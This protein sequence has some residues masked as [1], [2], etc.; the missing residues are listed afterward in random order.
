ME[1]REHDIF[2]EMLDNPTA[3]FDTMVTVGLNPTNTSLQSRD[4]Y[5]RDQWVIDNFKNQYGQFDETAFNK[6]YDVANML[7]NNLAKSSYEESMKKQASFHRDNI[8]APV[9]QRRSGPDFKQIKIANP[10]EQ[11]YNLNTLGRIDQPTKSIDELAQSH[12][13]LSNPTTAGKNLENAIWDDSPNDKFWGNFFETLVLAQYDEDGTHID[14]TSGETVEHKKG[15]F[16]LN[17]EGQFYYEK[18][19]GRDVYG[20]RIL[21]KMNVLTTDGSFWNKY[22]FFDS[23]DIEQKSIGGTALKNLA[24]VGSMFIP[25][26]GPWI[27]GFSIA[28][29]LAGLGATFGKMA[30]GSDNS[31]LS[32]IEGWSKSMNRQN[33]KTQYAQENTWCWENFI[34]LIGDVMGQLKEQRFIFEKL[35][36]AIKGTNVMT[37]SGRAA[38]LEELIGKRNTLTNQQLEKLAKD[39]DLVSSLGRAQ[40]ELDAVQTLKAQADLDSF[41]KGYQKLGEVFS[42][43]YMTAIT[44]GDTY[45]EAKLAGASDLDATLLTLGYAAGEYALLSTGLGEW[46][47][48]ELRANRYK[49][50]AIAKALTQLDSETQNLRQQFG[51]T[52]KNFPKEQKK[53]YTKKLF[54]IGKNIATAEYA[55]G[56]K[57]LTASLAAG[58]GEGFEEVSEEVLADFSKGCYDVVNWLRGDS[59]RLNTFGYDF[60]KG[61]WDASGTLDRYGMSL[62]GGFI[63]GGLTNVAT[64]YNSINS[65]NNMTSQQAI[66]EMVYM[67]RNGGLQDFLKQVDKMQLGDQNLS[68]TDFQ[69]QKDGSIVFSPGTQT[70]NQDLYAKQAIKQQAKL[71]ESILQAN[72]AALSDKSFL[73]VQTLGDLR[74]NALHQS[75]TAGA[76]LNE[77]N[78][79]S[80]DLVKLTNR[81]NQQ[82]ASQADTNQDG[83][84][85]DKEKRE[86]SSTDN[87]KQIIKQ[88]EEQIKDT[89]QQLQDLVQGKRSYEFIADSLF[90]MTNNLSSKFTTTT[91]PL[92]AERKYGRKFSELTENDKAVAW[93]EYEQWKSGEGR[94]RIREMSAIYRQIA[95]QASSVIKDHQAEY[96]RN[97]QEL[98]NLDRIVSNLYNP[99]VGVS[100]ELWLES[101]Q[102]FQNS[103][104]AQLKHD[105][106]FTFGTEEDKKYITEIED[107]IRQIDPNLSKEEKDKIA[108]DL[109]TK[110][111]KKQ[112]EII[113]N[114]INIYID[115]IIKAGFINTETKAQISRVLNNLTDIARNEAVSAEQNQDPFDPSSEDQIIYWSNKT[116]ELQNIQKQVDGLSNT[117]FEKNL[118]EFSISIGNDPINITQLLEKLNASLEDSSDNITKFNM[119]E[120]LYRNLDNAIQTIQLYQA[121]ILGARTDA[122]GIDNYYGYNA[123]LNEVSQQMDDKR[124]ELAEI[125]SNTADIFIEDINTNLN[126]L[127]FLKKLYQINQ[128]QKMSKQDRVSTKKDI[129]I[130]RRLKN[131]VTVPDDDNLKTWNGFLEL[132][133]A[134]N[135]MS[136]HE[137]LSQSNSDNVPENQKADFEKE[138]I[139]IEDAIYDFFQANSDKLNDTNK[140]SEF[141]N[142]NKLQIYTNADG[143]LNEGLESLDDNSILW[144]LAGRAA[145]K[146]SDFYNQYRQI[147]DPKAKNPLAPIPTQELAVYE[148]YASIVNGTVFTQFYKAIRQSI[149]NDW[150]K[151]SIDQRREI[152]KS[153]NKP[154]EFAQDSFSDY[155]LDI[156]SVPRYSN[157]VLTEGIPGSGKTSAVFKQTIELL[158]KFNPDLL[159]NVA[160]VH[161]ADIDSAKKISQ[162]T[163]LP[164][165]KVY[166]REEWMREVNPEWKEYSIDPTTDKY[167]VPESDFQFT[168]E[169]EI[170]SALGIKETSD[171]P[172]LVIIDEI[173]KF[174]VYDLDQIDK[175]A[176]KYGITV[177]AAGD[178]DQSGVIGQ[179][180]VTINGQKYGWEMELERTNFIRSPKL[181]VSMRTDN[182]LKTEDLQKFQAYMQDPDNGEVE[183][184]YF[185]DETGLYG[186]KVH[187]YGMDEGVLGVLQSVLQD[188]DSLISTLKDGEKIGYIYSDKNSDIYKELSSDKYS[189]YIDFKKG[190]TA[191]GL[192]GRYYIIEASPSANLQSD[193]PLVRYSARRRYLRDIYTGISR[194]QQGSI[195]IAPLNDIKFKSTKVSQKVNESVGSNVI[196]QYANRRKTLLDDVA[197]SGSNIKYIPRQTENREVVK[198][199]KPISSTGLEDG[200]D[201]TP[202]PT[203]QPS[204]DTIIKQIQ[205]AEDVAE[206]DLIEYTYKDSPI[207]NN[208]EVQKA[209]SEK[210]RE[211]DPE[212]ST[213]PIISITDIPENLREDILKAQEAARANPRTDIGLDQDDSKSDLKYGQI[214]KLSS[215]FGVI[216][217]VK[218]RNNGN[219]SY[220][221]LRPTSPRTDNIWGY[222]SWPYF[223]RN[224]TA[225]VREFPNKSTSNEEHQPQAEPLSYEEDQT[226]ITNTDII[227]QKEY[228]QNIDQS[229]QEEYLPQSNAIQNDS[230]SVGIEMLLHTFN[231]FETGVLIG[232]DGKPLPVGDQSWADARIDSVNGLVKIDQLLGKSTRTVRQ[233]IEQIGRLRS[234][235]FNIKDKSE[236]AQ[237]L[238]T[239]LGLPDIYITFALKSSPRPGDGNK[240]QGREFVESKPTP[241]SKGISE[242][243]V[244]NG[245]SDTRSHEWHP[246]SVVAIIGTKSNGNILELPLMAMSSPFTL[247]Q[248]K[249]ENGG[250]VYQ[251][252]YDQFQQ[253]QL[254]GMSIHDISNSLIKQFDG[255]PI[256]KDLINLFKLFNFTERGIS[257]IKDNEWTPAKSLTLVGPQFV[258]NRGYYQGVPGLEYD[259][260]SIPESEWQSV[261]EFATNPQCYVTKKVLVSLS[262]LADTG[263]GTSIKI[264]NAGHPF[265]LVSYDRE[266]NSDKKVIDYYIRQ[267]SDSSALPKVKLMYILPPKASIEEYVENLRKI[268]NREQGVKNIGQLFTSYK[269]IKALLTSD[270][271]KTELERKSPGVLSKVTKA[272]E[273]IDSLP[274]V[275]SKKNKLYEPQNWSDVGISAKPVKLAGLFDGV[276][277][278]FLYNKN[279]LNSLIGGQNQFTLDSQSLEL[280]KAVLQQQGIDGIYYNVKIPKDGGEQI[281]PFNVPIQG[282]NYTLDGKPFTIHGKLDSYVFKGNMNWLVDSFLNS[283]RPSKDGRYQFTIDGYSYLKGESDIGTQQITPQQREIN[284]LIT[285]IKQKIGSDFSDTYQNY[286]TQEAN[287][288]IV[289]TINSTDNSRIA[290]TIGNRLIISNQNQALVGNVWLTDNSNNPVTDIQQFANNNGIYNF[291]VFVR[292]SSYVAEFNNNTEE[293][294]LTP[295]I[296]EQQI[297]STLSVTAES[298]NNYMENARIALEDMLIWDP[299]YDQIF[300]STTYEEFIEAINNSDIIGD[301]RI[302]DL[303]NALDNQGITPEQKSIIEELINFEKARDNAEKQDSCPISIKIKF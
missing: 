139:Q 62:V 53:E 161:G 8:W 83:T 196:S 266:L 285:Y 92:Y 110:L 272:V 50:Q 46:I 67:S 72:G 136:L 122:A 184:Q 74:F 134:I 156:I 127:Q 227:P 120:Q 188:V 82:L 180:P 210:R 231:T 38:K 107:Q 157:I 173:S 244:F 232:S 261:S 219:H 149:V 170:R 40:T 209:L 264:A 259:N 35:P 217:G 31:T 283:L 275:I 155:A 247:L 214:V 63:G 126:K 64:N 295:E 117:P 271:F 257:Y 145:V 213:L 103:S 236:L 137:S 45:E 212:D 115:P 60:D 288:Q 191:Q 205:E 235:I 277:M 216:V 165:S 240:A 163:N 125:D 1:K 48:P 106:V 5:K 265:V 182:S 248:I 181:G 234:L 39:P 144:W 179:H 221:V 250:Y 239:N 270:S 207:L 194:A 276:L 119:D 301:E 230:E 204:I 65:I 25:Y 14:P 201:S 9:E 100:E 111:V 154:E 51:A 220:E 79:L 224:I 291:K 281:G 116:V 101:T 105:L 71:I 132:Q 135:G 290:F 61:E 15:D 102:Q 113:L 237:K 171:P 229:N 294:T 129:L 147:I 47:L 195:L 12:K 218:L 225:V 193:Q 267:Q 167:L 176:R 37:E 59:T 246:K 13:V 254:E 199:T 202:P 42:K 169:N 150:K 286:S 241:F 158:R 197:P 93:K 222:E 168:E 7:Y 298:F 81:L 114:N 138:K 178:F 86:S 75:T 289:G 203:S 133:N 87:N 68:A 20:K 2:M 280:V 166:G 89:K 253:L 54:N 249:D 66:Q 18:L 172:S 104:I 28:T 97:Y 128:G 23:D 215:E 303:N 41:I 141:L 206:V 118:N 19:D 268:L 175:F 190:G 243:T 200:A 108:K 228:Q 140:L 130:Y 255:N 208:P 282:N 177:L 258:T 124:P 30:A 77:F 186:D 162:D 123:T 148:N 70:N 185:S 131:I 95:E 299:D 56:A 34:G 159:K 274:D 211:V 263:N 3:S 174:S 160:I 293:L 153:L 256:Y 192:E 24:L 287:K 96:L 88:L 164:E 11:V 94:D 183:F 242:Q 36:Y 273:E 262:G 55:N 143:L 269:L 73:D 278:T 21:N 279:T 49:N 226:P 43:G 260:D 16:K 251:Q 300:K 98:Q 245:S 32:A 109:A 57:T 189:R 223:R 252:V 29:Q 233:Y 152:L 297:T 58:A 292:N 142:P 284:N 296:Q 76:Y 91:F 69:K 198:A 112:S 52:L 26:V 6:A 17:N 238:A 44:V 99:I 187:N 90:E 78:T 302:S 80:S 22:D 151:K 33:A 85:A 27:A 84:V 146:S 121:A 10:Y 4:T